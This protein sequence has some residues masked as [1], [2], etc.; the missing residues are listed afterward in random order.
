MNGNNN[1]E[2]DRPDGRHKE[3]QIADTEDAEEDTET[4]PTDWTQQGTE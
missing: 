3:A 4:R 1:H 2:D